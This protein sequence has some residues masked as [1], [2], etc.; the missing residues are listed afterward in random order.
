VTDASG[1]QGSASVTLEVQSASPL[2]GL[3]GGKTWVFALIGAA[4]FLALGVAG[5]VILYG[6]AR[7]PEP[8]LTAIDS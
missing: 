8:A 7:R 2:A 3:T 6:A 5:V 4:A 1:Q